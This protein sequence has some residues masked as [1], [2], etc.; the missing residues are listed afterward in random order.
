MACK[1]VSIYNVFENKPSYVVG[2]TKSK[3][4]SSRTFGKPNQEEERPRRNKAG[5]LVKFNVRYLS[6]RTFI[7]EVEICHG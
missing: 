1:L 2:D 5:F 6:V 3:S 7:L 4:L